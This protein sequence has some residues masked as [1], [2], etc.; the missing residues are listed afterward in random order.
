MA[1]PIKEFC[2]IKLMFP[3]ES[4]EQAFECKKK[5]KDMLS[6]ISNSRIDFRI[7]AGDLIPTTNQ[8]AIA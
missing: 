7:I 6:N 1:E 8:N 4:D 5:V 3:I 2:I